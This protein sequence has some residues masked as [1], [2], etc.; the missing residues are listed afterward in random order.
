MSFFKWIKNYKIVEN[1]EDEFNRKKEEL[2][3]L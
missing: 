1:L 2:L 3:G